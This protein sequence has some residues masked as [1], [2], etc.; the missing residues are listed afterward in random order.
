[1]TRSTPS[2][3]LLGRA[4]AALRYAVTGQSPAAW[5]GPG[6]PLPLCA[7]PA[8]VGR[9]F[10]F[11]V[12]WNLRVE[13]R[14]E[15]TLSFADLRALA[16]SWDLLRL[17]IETRKDQLEALDW[18]IAPRRG[19]GTAGEDPRIDWLTEL[20][21]RPDREHGWGPW[22]RML[23][24]DLFVIDAPTLYVRRD[25]AG[26]LFAL[27]PIDGATI[28]RVLADDG[29]TPLAP[30]PAYQQVLKGIPAVDY[31]ADELIY[32]PRNPRA[33]R[34][35]GLSPVEQ[36]VLTI[37]VA[38]RRQLSQLAYFTEGNTPDALVSVPAAWSAEQTRQYQEWWD[39]VMQDNPGTRRHT[40]F[41]PGAMHYMPT[42]DVLLKDD[43]DEWLAR[44]VCFAFSIPPTALVR[45]INRATAETAHDTALA[46][47]LQPLMSWLKDLIDRVIADVAGWP[48]LEFVWADQGSVDP[49]VQAQIDVAYVAAGIKTRD[50]V[51]AQLGLAPLSI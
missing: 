13:P 35:Y 16:D 23:L 26:R 38:L 27:E 20:L 1:M 8:P 30:A 50:E 32:A 7:E 29:R 2:T 46:E 5:F 37:N 41:V 15:A 14:Q 47:G 31:S 4:A 18:R 21:R 48:D 36:I 49:Q 25:Q 12:G 45:Q 42:R 22:C 10:D 34:V 3:A 39:S 24:E 19:K 51:R 44:V 17:V 6:T 43:F 28:K 9:Q 40:R 11:P 33:H